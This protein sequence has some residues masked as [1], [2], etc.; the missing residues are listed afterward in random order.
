[1]KTL[2]VLGAALLTVACLFIIVIKIVSKYD[3]E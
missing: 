1:M 3:E 2:I